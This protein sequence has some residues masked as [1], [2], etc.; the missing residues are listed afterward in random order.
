M[1]FVLI[2]N[3]FLKELL[4]KGFTFKGGLSFAVLYFIFIPIW[5]LVLTGRINLSVPDFGHYTSLTDVILKE[6]IVSS[7]KLISYLFAFTA[8]FYLPDIKIPRINKQPQVF[9]SYTI[10][11][12]YIILLLIVFI[13][14][15]LLEGGNWYDDREQFLVKQ[16]S[17]AV[18]TVYLLNSAKILIITLLLIKA[19]KNRKK[20]YLLYAILFSALDMFLSGNRIYFFVTLVIAGLYYFRQKP[21]KTSIILPLVTPLI[22]YIGYFGS[23]FRHIRGPLF[24]QG[25]PTKELFIKSF[26]RAI[27]LD[28]F[29]W[30][31]FF[32]NISES[33]NVNVI[34]DILNRYDTILY[35][36][37]YIKTFIFYIPRSIWHSKPETIT[38]IA[39][40]FFGGSSL[41]TTIIGEMQMNF[42]SI[43]PVFLFTA[44]I[45]T[46]FFMKT[47]SKNYLQNQNIFLFFFGVLIFRMP[48][49]DEILV[50]VF[51][52]IIVKTLEKIELFFKK[53]L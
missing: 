47:I 46:E 50:F 13:G 12:A 19:E 36:S 30:Q 41:V 40:D 5:V 15:G 48:F 8:Y 34:F 42:G 51:L 26:E 16:G 23:I 3:F 20:K 45:L 17:K 4:K 43:A 49:S 29:E 9:P 18:I 14:S 2:L 22:V 44:L 10:F 39:A 27:K 28:P 25:L 24:E 6:E 33:V 11:I 7:L 53:S 52:I 1:E 38:K 21:I 31:S 37:T 32:L 35:G